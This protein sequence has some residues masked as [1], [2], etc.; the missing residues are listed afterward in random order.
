MGDSI[1]FRTSSLLALGISLAACRSQ[2]TTARSEAGSAGPIQNALEAR[3][4]AEKPHELPTARS[5]ADALDAA[6]PEPAELSGNPLVGL[7]VEDFR[8]AAVSVP[9][10]SRGPRPVVIA[11]HG[12]YD[13]PEWQCSVWREITEG[14]PW[15]LCPRGIPRADAPKGLDRWTYGSAEAVRSELSAALQALAQAYPEYVDAERPIFG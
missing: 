6:P 1:L 10:G 9:L 3:G 4:S 8:T 14:V 11:L 7:E 12:N 5:S 15:V 2:N 13:R